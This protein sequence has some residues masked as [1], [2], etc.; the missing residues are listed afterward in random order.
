M[1]IDYIYRLNFLKNFYSTN[2]IQ[3]GDTN[4]DIFTFHADGN[5]AYGIIY[6]NIT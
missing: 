1:Y 3:R 4:D 2:K 6:F 5:A